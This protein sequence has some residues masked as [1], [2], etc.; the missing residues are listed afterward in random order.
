MSDEFSPSVLLFQLAI[1]FNHLVDGPE[2]VGRAGGLL[3]RKRQSVGGDEHD[4]KAVGDRSQK[5]FV[6][7]SS[8]SCVRDS[9]LVRLAYLPLPAAAAN[10]LKWSLSAT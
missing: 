10:M 2:H 5:S 8:S 3:L 4:Q 6:H 9:L 1:L 7:K